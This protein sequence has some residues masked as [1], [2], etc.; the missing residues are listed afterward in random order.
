[1]TD[2]RIAYQIQEFDSFEGM[3]LL[4]DNKRKLYETAEKIKKKRDLDKYF[5]DLQNAGSGYQQY[6]IKTL[7]RDKEVHDV[8]N[9]IMIKKLKQYKNTTKEDFNNLL[10]TYSHSGVDVNKLYEEETKRREDESIKLI[11]VINN[12][13][14]LNDISSDTV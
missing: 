7:K 8:Y 11:Q 5:K 4:D 1:M 13:H 9:D 3:Y 10:G 14:L 6:S 12:S 2:L